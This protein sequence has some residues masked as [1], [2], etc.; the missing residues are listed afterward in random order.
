MRLD[1]VRISRRSLIRPRVGEGRAGEGVEAANL[2]LKVVSR[3]GLRGWKYLTLQ[4]GGL[5]LTV[6]K[7]AALLLQLGVYLEQLVDQLRFFGARCGVAAFKMK[8]LLHFK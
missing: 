8:I 3:T 5:L 7:L 4:V 2:C 1:Y 6:L